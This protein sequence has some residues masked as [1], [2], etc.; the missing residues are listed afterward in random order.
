MPANL[1]VGGYENLNIRLPSTCLGTTTVQLAVAM[2]HLKVM[3]LLLNLLHCTSITTSHM[4][5]GK[6]NSMAHGRTVSY[7]AGPRDNTT[8]HWRLLLSLL[9]YATYNE[10]RTGLAWS[11]VHA[12]W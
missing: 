11:P 3:R 10:L 6:S 9:L 8:A 7:L 5:V 1:N 4:V 2:S 12:S